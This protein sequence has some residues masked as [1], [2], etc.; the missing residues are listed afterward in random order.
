MK[1]L[2]KLLTIVFLFD[3]LIN[4]AVG[5]KILGIFPLTIKS[6]DIFCHSV[7][8]AL[9]KRGHYVDVIVARELENSPK[10]YNV[11]Y[12]TIKITPNITYDITIDKILNIYKRDPIKMISNEFGNF[13]CSILANGEIQEIIKK[14]KINSNYDVLITE[15][16]FYCRIN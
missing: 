6:H 12:N 15:V 4:S 8:K 1:F 16:Q 10:N 11:L 2:L 7:I 9:L 5:Y 13:L 3:I 14:L